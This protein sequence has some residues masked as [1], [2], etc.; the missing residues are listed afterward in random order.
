MRCSP[1]GEPLLFKVRYSA[2][3]IVALRLY[4]DDAVIGQDYFVTL[5]YHVS[6]ALKDR[7]LRLGGADAL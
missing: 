2:L 1:S 3:L 5:V 7:K 4:H 6:V